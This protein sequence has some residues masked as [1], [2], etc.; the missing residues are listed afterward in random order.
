M[1]SLLPDSQKLFF[2]FFLFSSILTLPA[3]AAEKTSIPSKI[4]LSWYFEKDQIIINFSYDKEWESDNAKAKCKAYMNTGS[5]SKTIAETSIPIT[6][7]WSAVFLPVDLNESEFDRDRISIFCSL[8]INNN[9]FMLANNGSSES[10]D[11]PESTQAYESI[12]WFEDAD[13]YEQALKKQKET[14]A[15]MVIYFFTDWCGYCRKFDNKILDSLEVRNYLYK[16]IKVR[17]NPDHGS[18][19]KKL[20]RQFNVSGYPS[21]FIKQATTPP[22]RLN[23]YRNSSEAFINSCKNILGD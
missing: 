17:I 20:S 8:M 16:I 6:D 22:I 18:L 2:I 10:M 4:D 9:S 11:E 1:K 15:P 5:G 23:R 21:F 12:Y 14:K 13:G 3:Q 7:N 19:D